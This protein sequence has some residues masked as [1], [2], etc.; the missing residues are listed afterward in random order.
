MA[1]EVHQLTVN[2]ENTSALWDL[3]FSVPQGELMGI[4]GPNGA[5]KST[6]L[7]ALIG[8]IT[9]VSGSILFFGKPL[10]CFK[11]Q[12]AYVPQKKSIDWNFPITVFDVVLMGRYKYL[13]G[14]KWYRKADKRAARIS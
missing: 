14:L 8:I 4:I 3:N 5:G 10:S 6:L 2:F 13:K 7:K 12:L 11:D 1:I 9:P